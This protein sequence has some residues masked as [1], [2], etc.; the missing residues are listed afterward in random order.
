MVPMSNS[1]IT[2]PNHHQQTA[3][4]FAFVEVVILANDEIIRGIL[5][6]AYGCKGGFS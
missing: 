3:K 2:S 6:A 1:Y 4:A 5:F